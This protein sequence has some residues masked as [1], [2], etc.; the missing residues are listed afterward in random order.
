VP[1]IWETL[2]IPVTSD[3]AKVRQ[4]YA[5]RLRSIDTAADPAAFIALRAAYERALEFCARA[6]AGPTRIAA[7]AP[8]KTSSPPIS[9]DVSGKERHQ[10]NLLD[11]AGFEPDRLMQLTDTLQRD[12]VI[13]AW[14]NYVSWMARG[15]ITLSQQIPLAKIILQAAVSD[16]SLPQDIFA[17]IANSLAP[18]TSSWRYGDAT[19]LRA[20]LEKRLAAYRWFDE[21]RNLAGMRQAGKHKYQVR[22]ARLFL[23][24]KKRFS[25]QHFLL[26]AIA[27]LFKKYHEHEAWLENAVDVQWAKSLEV[28]LRRKVKSNNRRAWIFYGAIFAF[29]AGDILFVAGRDIIEFLLHRF[30]H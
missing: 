8:I 3:K 10:E 1:D 15:D 7:A 6:D 16:K 21:L 29:L 22:A 28:A 19:A 14:K 5:A 9:P 20:A 18:D 23:G 11:E 12:G 25:R 2:G 30:G 13:A 26:N 24:K 17:Q 27:E 4:A